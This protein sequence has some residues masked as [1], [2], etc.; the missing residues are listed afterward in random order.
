MLAS[1]GSS[2]D[3]EGASEKMTWHDSFLKTIGVHSDHNRRIFSEVPVFAE[4]K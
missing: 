3:D 2:G 1:S 4:K